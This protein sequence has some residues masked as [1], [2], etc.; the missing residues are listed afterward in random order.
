MSIYHKLLIFEMSGTPYIKSPWPTDCL[1]KS[2]ESSIPIHFDISTSWQSYLFGYHHSYLLNTA[3]IQVHGYE[4]LF[5]DTLYE[6]Q[7]NDPLGIQHIPISGTIMEC[8]HKIKYRVEYPRLSAVNVRYETRY[9]VWRIVAL[10]YVDKNSD[11]EVDV[12]FE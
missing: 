12:F 3:E 4:I 9:Y 11:V 2:T 7:H 8:I 6:G 5:A 1:Y 10:I